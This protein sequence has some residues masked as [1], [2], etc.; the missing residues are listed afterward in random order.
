MAEKDDLWVL[1]Y[2]PD[3]A[4]L[5][6]VMQ[7]APTEMSAVFRALRYVARELY[8][9]RERGVELEVPATPSIPYLDHD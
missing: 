9:L 2:G 6:R 5:P 8:D 7:T 1:A 4:A 3:D